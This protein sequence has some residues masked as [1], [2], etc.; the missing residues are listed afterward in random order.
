[1]CCVVTA[2]E[3]AQNWPAKFDKAGMVKATRIPLGYP[4]RVKVNEGD[5]D[6]FGQVAGKRDEGFFYVWQYGLQCLYGN[7]GF[8]AC[9]IRISH[10]ERLGEAVGFRL[11]SRCI[12]QHVVLLNLGS[13]SILEAKRRK[14]SAEDRHDVSEDSNAGGSRKTERAKERLKTD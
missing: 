14:R 7:E 4:A 13:P 3:L 11:T 8:N 9:K 6:V 2:K 12:N 10:E 5:V 1:M